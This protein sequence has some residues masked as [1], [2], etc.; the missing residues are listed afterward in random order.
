MFKM[1]IL[2]ISLVTLIPFLV[3]SVF[4]QENQTPINT[5]SVNGTDITLA[6]SGIIS[7]LAVGVSAFIKD[8]MDKK[9]VTKNIKGTDVD[10]ANFVA[11]ISKVFQYA[12][13]YKN[14]SL[15]Q[16]LDLPS[17]S[18]VMD[19][20]T[21]GQAISNE[22]NGWVNYVQEV[23]NVPR[24]QMA[25]ASQSIVTATQN[26]IAPPA[27]QDQPP[28]IATTSPAPVTAAATTTT[29]ATTEP[30]TPLPVTTE[31]T[32]KNNNDD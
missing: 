18:N 27:T 29:T 8:R 17:T 23:Y 9:A 25:I 2:F 14:Y 19:K 1:R 32:N 11:L 26:Q 10:M 6:S 30:I 28:T 7:A 5:P 13:V 15:S 12:Y 4:A 3:G 16:I 24:P 20:T 21:L 22:A 31:Q